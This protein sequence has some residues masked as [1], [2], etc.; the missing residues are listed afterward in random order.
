MISLEKPNLYARPDKI[1][2]RCPDKIAET[3]CVFSFRRNTG[4][5]GA[6]VMSSG[7]V[8]QSLGPATANERSPTVTSRNRGMTSSEE[9][10]DRRRRRDVII[11][12]D[13]TAIGDTVEFKLNLFL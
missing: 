6:D 7:R 13:D 3:K 9:I 4:R 10:A 8:S 1:D 11:N 5:D 2:M 12:N